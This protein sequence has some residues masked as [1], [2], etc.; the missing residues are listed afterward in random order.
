MLFN[1]YKSDRLHG[2][3]V[4]KTY[5]SLTRFVE[6][7]TDNARKK[8][9]T[10]WLLAK[11]DPPIYWFKSCDSERFDNAVCKDLKICMQKSIN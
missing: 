11:R 2:N 9:D 10:C 8:K 3:S 1:N 6:C 4:S 5:H 7:F